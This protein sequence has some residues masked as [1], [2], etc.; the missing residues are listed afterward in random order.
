MKTIRFDYNGSSK[1][2]K[3]TPQGFLRVNAR[4][5]R[6][7][8]FDY[9]DGKEYRPDNEVFRTDSLESIKGA[10]VTDLHPSENSNDK[11]LSPANTKD[12]IIGITEGVERDGDYLKGSLIIFHEDAIKAI[13][14]G[15]R[16]EISLGYQCQIEKSPGVFKGQSYD[17]V[18]KNI[19]V[20][21]VAIGPKGWGRAGPE[22]SIRKDSLTKPKEKIMSETLRF[23]GL[24]IE[25]T[26]SNVEKI[27]AGHKKKL[28]EYQGRLDAAYSE[29]KKE[30]SLRA[31]LEK[32]ETIDAKVKSRLAIIDKCRTIM[33]D[34]ARF[35]GK[36]DD[37]IKLEAIKKHFPKMDLRDRDCSYID[38][39][40]ESICLD[41]YERNDSLNN[42]R[43]AM[44]SS[45]DCT[46]KAAYEKWIEQS[47]RM[48]ETPLSG[49]RG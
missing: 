25:L 19:I 49:H 9:A 43:E 13:E 17:A 20:N 28:A 39:V 36:S 22:C 14:S 32:P 21:H 35:D 15:D 12:H 26:P 4:L 31:Q 38:G 40:F 29:L 27:L 11:F 45:D 30:Q 48:W 41:K 10:P 2:F 37:E 42:A 1:S 24:D 47:A 23:D 33:G 44:A 7:G 46:P 3:R 34:D 18:Q 16:G 8:V 5:S 6:V